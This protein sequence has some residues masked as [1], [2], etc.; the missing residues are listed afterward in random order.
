MGER[1]CVFASQDSRV[2]RHQ[3]A[4]TAGVAVVDTTGAGDLFTAG[5]LYALAKGYQ[6]DR[7][8]YMG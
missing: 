7:C 3:P 1:G 6:L 4:Y 2:P 8:A 5:F